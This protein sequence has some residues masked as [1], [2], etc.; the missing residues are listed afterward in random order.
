MC[1]TERVGKSDQ[2]R[3]IWRVKRET[4]LAASG[5]DL[6]QIILGLG[7]RSILSIL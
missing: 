7:P 5:L 4:L 6:P 1:C 2:N 3:C